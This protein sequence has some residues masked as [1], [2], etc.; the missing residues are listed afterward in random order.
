MD[1]IITKEKI[2]DVLAQAESQS[3][4]PALISGA[5]TGAHSVATVVVDDCLPLAEMHEHARDVWYVIGGQG[6][7][8]LV[9]TLNN[10]QS[11]KPDAWLS[12]SIIDGE[13]AR[14]KVGDIIDIPPGVAHQLDARG[15]RLELLIVKI[16]Y[17]NEQGAAHYEGA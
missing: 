12:E 16:N 6:I 14:V 5:W 11:N 4:S 17:N 10:P 15:G 2:A 13:V 3:K 8:I 1:F 7:F 9:G